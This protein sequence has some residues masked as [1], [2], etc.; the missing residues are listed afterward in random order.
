MV[1]VLAAA[2][3]QYFWSQYAILTIL[4]LLTILGKVNCLR[5]AM[6]T[7]GSFC[8]AVP[9]V[10]PALRARDD[11]TAFWCAAAL[12]GAVTA[13][14]FEPTRPFLRQ[15]EP[16]P[17]KLL[18]AGATQARVASAEEVGIPYFAGGERVGSAPS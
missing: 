9:S 17:L 4:T 12:F 18:L 6:V 1:F 3:N 16:H 5:C 7:W 10:L 2:R 11:H 15:L 13:A 14:R 8:V